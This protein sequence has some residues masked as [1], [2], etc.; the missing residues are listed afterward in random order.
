MVCVKTGDGNFV[1]L[2]PS[3]I[4]ELTLSVDANSSLRYPS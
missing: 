4:Y 1:L 3:K 2:F